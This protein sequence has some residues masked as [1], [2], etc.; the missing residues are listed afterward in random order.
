MIA[1]VERIPATPASS[2][3]YADWSAARP[4]TQLAASNGFLSSLPATII[5]A[6]VPVSVTGSKD[7]SLIALAVPCEIAVAIAWQLSSGSWTVSRRIFS[8]AMEESNASCIQGNG[9]SVGS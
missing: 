7:P 4:G 6:D 2:L 8:E 9:P 3:R 5:R 1:T